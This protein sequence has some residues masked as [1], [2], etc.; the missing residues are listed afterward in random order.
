MDSVLHLLQTQAGLDKE[1]LDLLALGKYGSE[2][3]NLS[4]DIDVIFLSPQ[5]DDSILQKTRRFIKMVNQKSEWGFISR[6]DLN[7]KPEPLKDR[8]IV[9][10]EGLVDYLWHS[11]E[12]WERLIYTRSRIVLKNLTESN[13][14]N[15][16]PLIKRFCY[17]KYVNMNLIEDLSSLLQKILHNNHDLNNIKLRPGGIRSLELFFNSLQILYGGRDED[18]QTSNTYRLLEH[19]ENKNFIRN[20]DLSLLKKNYD[21]LRRV[22]NLIQIRTDSQHHTLHKSLPIKSSDVEKVCAEN[23]EIL[24]SFINTVIGN[25]QKS[26]SNFRLYDQEIDIQ[27]HP[28]LESLNQFLDKRPQYKNLILSHPKTFKGLLKALIYSPYLSKILLLRPDLFDLFLIKKTVIHENADDETL[29]RDLVDYKLLNHITALGDFLIH[30]DVDALTSALSQT[31]D[32]CINSIIKRVLPDSD[33]QLLRLGKWSG[34]EL[35]LKSDLDFVF[36]CNDESIDLK[37][38][39]K[40]I[41]YIGH[42]TFYGAFYNI[43]LRLRPSGAAGPII[44]HPERLSSFLSSQDTSPWMKQ[45]YLRNSFLKTATKFAFTS[46]D[47]IITDSNINE[48][49][50]IR[51]K[52]LLPISDRLSPKESQGG[53]IDL[54]FFIQHLCLAHRY[55]PKSNSFAALTKE[56]E[57]LG[58]LNAA[59]AQ[60]LLY[61]YKYLR[62]TEQICSLKSSA[63]ELILTEKNSS[64]IFDLPESSQEFFKTGLSHSSLKDVLHHSKNLIEKE[65]P[66][67]L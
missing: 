61:Y 51:K 27:K 12:L 44:T 4:S 33:L 8:F 39:R 16:L 17:R 41:H 15:Y 22:E 35:G 34:A 52:R 5:I 48:L 47:F 66:F 37:K 56:L 21:F 67:L 23:Y 14:E 9:S 30:Y 10:P 54:E 7:L 19:L 60:Q 2:V 36:V 25:K 43:D 13:D 11:S 65:H 57:T 59:T 28:H 46:S 50:D 3:L 18:L 38:I 63:T 20:H 29:L 6:I 24:Q 45:S 26:N 53:L 64:D 40:I 58:H 49:L 62:T 42:H 55:Y 31:A 32:K 1:P